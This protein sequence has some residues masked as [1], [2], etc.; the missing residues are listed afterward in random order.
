MKH[1]TDYFEIM[2]SIQRFFLDYLESNND[3]ENDLQSINILYDQDQNQINPQNLKAI[4]HLIS[5]ISDNHYRS[6]HFFEKIEKIILKFKEEIHQ[7]CSNDEI[8]NIFKNNKRIILFL[9]NEQIIKPNNYIACIIT[10]NDYKRKKYPNYF[11][12]EFKPLFKEEL[13]RE[14]IQND[15][16]SNYSDENIEFFNEKRKS[17]EN[18]D[19]ICKLIRNDSVEDFVYNINKANIS[20]SS[21]IRPSIFETN[22]FLLEKMPT[23]IEYSAF[24]G[25]IKIFKYLYLNKVELTPSLWNYAI[26]G[27]YSELIHLLEEIQL[28]PINNSFNQCFY[29]SIK[30]HHNELAEYLRSNFLND[31]EFVFDIQKVFDYY[32]YELIDDDINN[33]FETLLMLCKNDYYEIVKFL[34]EKNKN[35]DVNTKTVSKTFCFIK[36]KY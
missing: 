3:L 21:E 9:L 19:F 16:D 33:D 20:L 30:C 18:E 26:H 13:I 36:F 28:K 31:T 22:P 10:K 17:G 5:N 32:N 4:L 15:T 23:I 27:N 14:I 34:L 6:T 29:E 35:F 7:F 1:V 2:K 12:P 25:S 8:F 11:Y 24:Y